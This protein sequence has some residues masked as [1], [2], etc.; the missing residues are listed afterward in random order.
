VELRNSISCPFALE[1]CSGFSRKAGETLEKSVA[2]SALSFIRLLIH[3]QFAAM[4][5]I[6]EAVNQ[7]SLKCST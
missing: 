5:V 3:K 1:N 4:R 2:T 6:R 7:S